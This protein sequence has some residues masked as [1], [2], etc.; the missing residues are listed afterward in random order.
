MKSEGVDRCHSTPARRCQECINTCTGNGLH[1]VVVIEESWPA[2]HSSLVSGSI[3]LPAW[4]G[5]HG[6]VKAHCILGP[7]CWQ[8]IC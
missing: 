6:E 7:V 3:R 8:G 2:G 4:F 5:E 1:C